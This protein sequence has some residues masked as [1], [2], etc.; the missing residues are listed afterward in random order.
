MLTPGGD[1]ERHLPVATAFVQKGVEYTSS[2]EL[3]WNV[4]VTREK[5]SDNKCAKALRIVCGP[6]WFALPRGQG[7]CRD[8]RPIVSVSAREGLG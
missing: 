6:I 5:K 7:L 4:H 1:E 2:C 8:P 3:S